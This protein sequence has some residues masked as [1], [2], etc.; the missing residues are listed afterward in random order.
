MDKRLISR[1]AKKLELR[2][3]TLHTSS[4]TRNEEVDPSSYPSIDIKITAQVKSEELSFKD[5]S[6]EDISILRSFIHFT[7]VGF[8]RD[9][10]PSQDLFAI[11]TVYR[12]DYEIVKELTAREMEEFSMFNILHNTWPFWREHIRY[13]SNNAQFPRITIPLFSDTGTNKPARKKKRR[14]A[15]SKRKNP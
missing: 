1:A 15:V 2:D 12:V 9:E 11:N 5:E 7:L 6:D 8:P 14:K 3:I 10:D 13:I 4:F